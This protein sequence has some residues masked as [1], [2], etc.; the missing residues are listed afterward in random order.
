MIDSASMAS[1]SENGLDSKTLGDMSYILI[2]SM[3]VGGYVVV[4]LIDASYREHCRERFKYMLNC[5]ENM[6][7]YY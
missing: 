5:I 7:I 3:V 6:S 4:R 2:V 1:F